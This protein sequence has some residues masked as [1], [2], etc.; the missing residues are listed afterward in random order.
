[1]KQ[2]TNESE[3]AFLAFSAYVSVSG[4]GLE[5]AY[6]F[7]CELNEEDPAEIIPDVWYIWSNKFNWDERLQELEDN[8]TELTEAELAETQR[9][10]IIDFRNRQIKINQELSKTARLLLKRIRAAIARLDP[11]NI[12]A[13]AIPNFI[14]SIAKITELSIK[15]ES[16][17]LAIADLIDAL[18]EIAPKKVE[19]PTIKKIQF[20]FED[21]KEVV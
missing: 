10:R 3:A 17:Q 1:M 2:L 12:P 15:N 18:Q 6:R 9:N 5:A 8:D 13:S 4:I 14:N 11:E 16:D 21:I 7:Y 19:K 20:N